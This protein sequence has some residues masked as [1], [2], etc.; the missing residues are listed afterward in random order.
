M[1]EFLSIEEIILALEKRSEMEDKKY[2][3]VT[4]SQES[5]KKTPKDSFNLEGLQKLLKTM[6]N[7]M[8][9]I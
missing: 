2:K 8:N 7:D 9:E 5:K 1:K 3:K 6:S 4:F